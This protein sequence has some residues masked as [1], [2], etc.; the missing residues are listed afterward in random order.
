MFLTKTVKGSELPYRIK[1]GKLKS[2][3]DSPVAA[4]VRILSIGG[5][6]PI[7]IKDG[8]EAAQYIFWKYH[9]IPP[10]AEIIHILDT[11]S[12]STLTKHQS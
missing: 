6:V 3:G 11:N 7:N 2:A 12:F 4:M 9:T 1:W 5:Y 10:W 8:K